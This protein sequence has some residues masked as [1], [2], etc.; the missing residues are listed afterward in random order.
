MSEPRT[1]PRPTPGRYRAALL[2]LA[3]VGL[4]VA[5][6]GMADVTQR[7]PWY[8]N[9]DS[10]FHDVVD[11]LAINASVAPARTDQPGLVSK[12]LLA[13]DYRI[14]HFTG[15]LPVWNLKKLDQQPDPLQQIPGLIQLSRTHARIL[16]MLFILTAGALVYGITFSQETSLLIV[17]LLAASS[18]LLSHGLLSRP[19]LPCVWL[20]SVLAPYCVWQASAKG[21]RYAQPA[22]LF[23]AGMAAGLAALTKL[24]GGYYLLACYAW[25]WVAAGMG[26]RTEDPD[27]GKTG[28]QAIVLPVAS[29]ALIFWLLFRL[30]L[31]PDILADATIV[32]LRV[33]AAV[34]GTLPL[35]LLWPVRRRFGTFLIHRTVELAWLVGGA[36]AAIGLGYGALRSVMT[37]PRALEYLARILEFAVHPDPQLQYLL[38]ASPQVAR[39][40][41]HFVMESP[42]LFA[43]GTAAAAA[44]LTCTVPPRLKAL[45]G[46]LW[47]NAVAMTLLLARGGFQESLGLFAEVPLVLLCPLCLLALG[48]WQPRPPAAAEHWALPP[49]FAAVVVIL[50]TVTF[51]LELKFRSA[52]TE[53]EPPLHPQSIT[54]LYNHDVHPER[55][56]QIMSQHYGTREK[57]S[58]ALQH[59]LDDPAKRP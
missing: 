1:T 25:C 14:R 10:N 26:G 36:L 47:V 32:R 52:Q 12:Y 27:H 34:V 17:I 50:L 3:V 19:E 23:L 30:T 2:A 5:W 45:I 57:F 24:S 28:R 56:R 55:Y 42:F 8:D 31:V 9:L 59:Y 21:G 20:G 43:G 18:G 41:L 39:E 40:Y 44:A 51:R 29:A 4:V 53:M 22:W 46:L 13:L 58:A 38:P 6:Q 7:D 48:V 15:R 16:V 49:L 35:L 11:A 54:F 33:A 37:A